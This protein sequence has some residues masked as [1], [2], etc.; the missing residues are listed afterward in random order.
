MQTPLARR[1][2]SVALSVALSAALFAAS[3][4]PAHGQAVETPEQG[5]GSIR[6]RLPN[7][8]TTGQ[9]RFELYDQAVTFGRVSDPAMVWTFPANS[10]EVYEL[11][12]IEPGVYALG[13]HHDEDSNNRID[14]NFIGIPIEP[15]A[16]SRGYL[17]KGPPVYAR[18]N[19]TIIAED[20][21]EFEMEPE[22]FLGKRGLFSVG[23]GAIG[24]SLPYKDSDSSV[25][26]PI[27]AITFNGERLQWF[28]PSLI[29]GLVG[30][31][32]VRLA[33][34]ASYRL[35]TYEENDA[36]V[37][38]GLGDRE[39][40]LMAG[41]S[42]IAELPYGI[43]GSI[44]YQHDVLN[45]IGGGGANAQIQRGFQS[46]ITRFTPRIGLLWQ[47]DDLA[48][49]DFGVPASAAQPGRPAYDVG[50]YI[51]FEVGVGTFV[52]LTREWRIVANLA[53]EFLPSE[54]TNSPLVAD[55]Y[56]LKGFF[57]VTYVF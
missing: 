43:N 57:A 48:N 49:H 52:E 46:G 22:Y 16:F 42:V 31:D 50:D 56:V 45:Q 7:P 3:S 13:A 55:D 11:T 33:A 20:Q 51:S 4:V 5:T 29:Y 30:R 21:L 36:P 26:Q 2:L 15:I 18:A 27:P 35:R 1:A 25:L 47:S 10:G 53:V 39:D 28:G 12:G 24:R 40:T 32:R 37:L 34:T 19:F 6:V 23:V 8:P 14:K 54:V 9:L 38:A 17:P 41:L 44:G